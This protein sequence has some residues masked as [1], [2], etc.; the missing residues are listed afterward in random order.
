M[1]PEPFH[2]EQ[3]SLFLDHRIH[4]DAHV[5]SRIY[6]HNHKPDI[7]SYIY[8]HKPDIYIYIYIAWNNQ[9]F[10]QKKKYVHHSNYCVLCVCMCVCMYIYKGKGKSVP[11]HA[12]RG[13]K[14]SRK[15]RS[16]DFV[17]MA[18]DGGR[19]SALCTGHLHPQ[20]ILLVLISVRGRVDPSAIE[21]LE[22]LCQ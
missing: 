11:L 17:T 14:G 6:N 9:M 3:S 5:Y 13:P 8:N 4:N 16:P 18:Q 12:W 1:G 22:G 2:T 10:P 20:E 7:P 15:L 21:R 19:L